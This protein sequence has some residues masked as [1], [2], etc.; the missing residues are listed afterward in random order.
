MVPSNIN[1]NI[2]RIECLEPSAHVESIVVFLENHFI[3][4]ISLYKEKYIS[5]LNEPG[6]TQK[7]EFYLK[8]FLKEELSSFN[9]TKEYIEDTSTGISP[10]SDLAFFLD[11]DDKAIFCIEAKRIPTP[12][13]GREKEY[14]H[15]QSGKSGGIERFKKEIH[16]KGLSHSAIFGYVQREDFDYWHNQVNNWIEELILDSSQDIQW[17]ENDKLNKLSFN[18]NI[19]KFQS[20][21]KRTKD[22]IT[23]F[24]Y[25]LNLV[26]DS[27]NN[28]YLINGRRII[29]VKE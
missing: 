25:W 29:I 10:K 19:A 24:H 4:F 18:P 12:G 2:G 15:S 5:I 20:V 23:L 28:C 7:L 6:I 1:Y 22:T 8:P 27:Q 17:D 13:S 21:N 11:G 14:V 3:G 26:A 16:G 9:L